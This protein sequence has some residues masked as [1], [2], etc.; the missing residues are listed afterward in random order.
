MDDK[1]KDF[2]NED[3]SIRKEKLSE[4]L[5]N[6]STSEFMEESKIDNLL[7]LSFDELDVSDEVL[8]TV[9]ESDA[10][11]PHLAENV[12]QTIYKDKKKKNSVI[13]FVSGLAAV[14]A[15]SFVLM[16]LNTGPWQ[17]SSKKQDNP[18]TTRNQTKKYKEI[19][20]LPEGVVVKLIEDSTYELINNDKEFLRL[21]KGHVVVNVESRKN[22]KPLFFTMPDS[23]V[24]V[25]GTTFTLRCDSEESYV[26]VQEGSVEV[27]KD[28]KVIKLSENQFDIASKDFLDTG[29]VIN[30]L[31]KVYSFE[32]L[33]G[34]DFK[35]SPGLVKGIVGSAINFDGASQLIIPRS[36]RIHEESV[37]FWFK[38]NEFD[39]QPQSILGQHQINNSDNG[40]N[41]VINKKEQ[42]SLQ[43]KNR[44][45]MN[46]GNSLP[47]VE[48]KWYHAVFIRSNTGDYSFYVDGK[49]I[50]TE[51]F[52]Y[53]YRSQ[54]IHIGKSLTTYW[55]PFNGAVDELRIYSRPLTEKEVLKL[56]NR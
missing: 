36:G 7:S 45:K 15:L 53:S 48:N 13:Y 24:K 1:L 26:S 33:D 50:L 11:M 55:S 6:E 10:D 34:L 43:L 17:F 39:K 14:L 52:K 28:G 16:N 56:F 29:D 8:E 22:K 20:K 21:T 47:L 42:L 35:G 3:D 44:L 54:D 31:E 9:K 38:V 40:F 46:K 51:N 2:I 23:T 12:L 49:L 5:I 41:I 19:V 32:K 25:T 30:G 37:S 27:I 18:E 4:E